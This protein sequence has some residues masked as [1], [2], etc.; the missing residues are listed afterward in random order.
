MSLPIAKVRG[1]TEELA[2][3]M[4]EMGF[5]T[6]DDLLAAGRTP[7][8][9]KELAAKLGVD[10]KDLLVLVNH[11]DLARVTGIGE[12]FSNLLEEAGV[13]TV[14]ELAGRRADNLLT[15]MTEVNSTTNVAKRLPV[16][17][18]VEGWVAQAK[19]LDRGIEYSI[20]DMFDIRPHSK[21][22]T[23]T[24]ELYRR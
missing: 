3:S 20:H 12:V 18:Q 17:S 15:K 7:A 16:I 13:D 9:R 6:S 8:G 23:S 22:S 1:I 11:A 21:Y 5:K 14:V 19:E 2:A 24:I 4:K 10:G